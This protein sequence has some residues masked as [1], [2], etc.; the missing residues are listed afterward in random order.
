M[1]EAYR[2]VVPE[3]LRE[4]AREILISPRP[5]WI[6]FTSSSTVENLLDV[7]GVEALRGISVASIGPVTTA[8]LEKF[9]IPVA[10]EASVYTVEGLRDAILRAVII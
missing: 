6:T 1:V 3:D 9:G 4:R 10:A 7:V 5:Q 8:T 2:T